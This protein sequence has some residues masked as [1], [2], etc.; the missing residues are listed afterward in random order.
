MSA[1]RLVHRLFVSSPNGNP[2]GPG[3][4]SA[5][6]DEVALRFRSFTIT[7]AEGVFEGRPL[8]TLVISI[9]T[10]DTPAVRELDGSVGKQ[11]GQRQV[12]L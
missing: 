7:L 6:V 3:V 9:V 1:L 10:K 8:A 2:F 4:W 12:G 5:L 11:L